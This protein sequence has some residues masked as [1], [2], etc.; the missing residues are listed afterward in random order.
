MAGLA[1][2]AGPDLFGGEGPAADV[3]SHYRV[4]PHGCASREVLHTMAAQAEAGGFERGDGRAGQLLP[5]W[6]WQGAA[7]FGWRA[8]VL[9]KLEPLANAAAG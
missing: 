2:Q 7:A 5:R 3:A 8:N 6:H 1:Q 9:Q 4:G